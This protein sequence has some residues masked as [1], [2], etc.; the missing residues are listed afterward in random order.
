VQLGY[1]LGLQ[2]V[3]ESWALVPGT[4]AYWMAQAHAYDSIL[5]PTLDFGGYETASF[6]DYGVS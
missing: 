6:S 5:Y 1:D 4:T 2:L 3:Q